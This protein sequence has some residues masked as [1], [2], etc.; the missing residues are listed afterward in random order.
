MKIFIFGQYVPLPAQVTLPEVRESS[1]Y[2]VAGVGQQPIPQ[3][4]LCHL[5]A[6]VAPGTGGC[7]TQVSRALHY[8]AGALLPGQEKP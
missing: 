6:A 1:H 8:W 4:L 5:S 3:A 2:G 7:Q